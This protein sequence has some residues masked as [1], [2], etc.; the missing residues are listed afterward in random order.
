MLQNAR[1]CPSAA[2]PTPV[3]SPH[4]LLLSSSH[5]ADYLSSCKEDVV[6]LQE[7]WVDSDAQVL[8]ASAKQAG[9]VHATHFRLVER[10]YFGLVSPRAL[11]PWQALVVFMN[12]VTCALRVG[13]EARGC[14][15]CSMLVGK[16][17]S[18]CTY[19][20]YYCTAVVA[21]GVAATGEMTWQCLAHSGPIGLIG[22]ALNCSN[23]V[24]MPSTPH[25]H[26]HTAAPSA[27]YLYMC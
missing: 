6:L 15:A 4:F 26:S 16:I 9:L 11:R 21:C 3:F 22:F 14:R 24:L 1:T 2:G 8:I 7:V 17:W 19:G 12:N 10:L 20:L 13:W 27:C 5:L 18:R 25:K 23:K